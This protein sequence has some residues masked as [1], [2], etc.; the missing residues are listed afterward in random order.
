MN[1]LS[2]KTLLLLDGNAIIHRAYHALPPFATK[3][4]TVVNAVYGFSMT[5][6]SVIEKFHPT[7][8]VA[9]FDLRTPTF[10]HKMSKEYKAK[11]IKAPDELYEQIPIVKEVVRAF[12]IPIYEKEGFEAD[13]MIGSVAKRASQEGYEVIIVTGDMDALQLVDEH[14]KVFTM[15]RGIKDTIIYDEAG[16]VE[17]YGL[18][19]QQLPDYKGL[20]GDSSDNIAGV[21]G[22]GTKGATDLLQAHGS[23]EGVYEH[24][25]EIKSALQEKLL[26]DKAQAFQSKELGT[27]RLDAVEE[28]DWS[29]MEF[30]FS[31]SIREEVRKI[32]VDLNFFSLVKRIAKGSSEKES[33]LFDSKKTKPRLVREEKYTKIFDKKGVKNLLKEIKEKKSCTF[34]ID[35][36]GE[37]MLHFQI[38]GI[39]FT[40][41]VGRVF[42]VSWKQEYKEFFDA[43]FSDAEIQK[44]TYDLKTAWHMLCGEGIVWDMKRAKDILLSAYVLGSGENLSL[45]RLILSELGEEMDF[46]G[47]QETLFGVLDEK[48]LSSGEETFCQKVN[49]CQ[50]VYVCLE[51]RIQQESSL[52]EEKKTLR[53]ILEKVELPLVEILAQMERSGIGFDSRVFEGIAETLTKEITRLEQKIYELAGEEFNI[54]STKQLREILFTKLSI[55]AVKEGI[56]KTKTGYSTASSELQ[57]LKH[58]YP[59]AFLIEEYREL[60]KLKSTYVDTLP[61]LVLSDGRIHSTFNQAITATGR[62]SS[63]DPNLQNIPI[64]TELGRLLRT[65]FTADEGNVLVSADYSQIDLRCAAHVSGDTKMIEAFHKGEDIHM[66]TACEIFGLPPSKI[67][68]T[69]RRQAKVLNFGVLY[70]MGT[71]GFMNASGVK[72]DEAQNFIKAYQEKF[73]GLTQY[74]A[75]T[76]EFAREK[77]YVETE[78]GRRRYVPEIN[79]ANFQV[80]ASGERIAI[81]LPIQGLTADIMKLAMIASEKIVKSYGG[82]VKTILQI[83]DELVFEVPESQAKIFSQ[84][85]QKTMEAVYVLRVPL[86]VNIRNGQNWGEL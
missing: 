19:P 14:I 47:G 31:E 77:G 82:R 24:I 52:Q 38:R 33:F 54:N 72:R 23:L 78:L 29:A 17:K 80:V 55:D 86:V 59:I 18:K 39:A 25:E 48:K 30:V 3:D 81:N 45:E 37:D 74:L 75:K 57:K 73:S 26:R 41:Q 40:S 2:Q 71:F 15:R 34:M 12:Q 70:G 5:L 44:I 51:E 4:G 64:R 66:A 53:D 62:L 7:H 20:A 10:R 49:A 65:A 60:F 6:L 28:I 27:I 50:K 42:Y 67:T 13:D 56:K 76:K 8:V 35:G 16:V 68:K 58:S 63:S 83:H 36:K 46:G 85:I 21:S 11:R 22:I 1:T 84:E 69:Q 9:S 32:F 79:S 61:K 43:F